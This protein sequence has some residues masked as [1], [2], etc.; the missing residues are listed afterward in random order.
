MNF[1]EFKASLAYVVSSRTARAIKRDSC[2]KEK[3]IPR[4]KTIC[5]QA[6]QTECD[7]Q[8]PQG[9]RQKWVLAHAF[10]PSTWEAETGRA[11]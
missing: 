3:K 9:R 10:N 11:L 5:H 4:N 2:K 8:N 1:C 6:R 7:P